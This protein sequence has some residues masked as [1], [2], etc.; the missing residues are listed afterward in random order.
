MCGKCCSREKHFPC[1]L[2]T[3]FV[4]LPSDTNLLNCLGMI[5]FSPW[6]W[7]TQPS[8][9]RGREKRLAFTR[10]RLAPT[11]DT[12]IRQRKRKVSVLPIKGLIMHRCSTG[13]GEAGEREG[14]VKRQDHRYITHCGNLST[15]HLHTS[16]H[17]AG[18]VV[19]LFA[20]LA[21]CVVR[22]V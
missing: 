2:W 18:V 21:N 3:A 17:Q 1:S 9:D 19:P 20:F 14:A 22:H 4:C 11:K 7:K 12:E 15:S 10:C 6:N 8:R 5:G 13:V 16:A